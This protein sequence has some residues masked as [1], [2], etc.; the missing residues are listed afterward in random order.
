[1]SNMVLGSH[2]FVKQPATM[3]LIQ[4]DREVAKVKT[5][6]S[7]ALFSWGASII[8]KTIEISWPFMTTSEYASFQAIYEADAQVVFDPQD[9]SSKTYNVELL[10]LTSEYFI[11]LSNASGHNRR[12]VKL[13]LLIMS[14]V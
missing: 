9:G 10:S 13:T 1:M 8:G 7:V 6:S 11:H 2:T 12:N 14:E 5:Y 4:K 3:T